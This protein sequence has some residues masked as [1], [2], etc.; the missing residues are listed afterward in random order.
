MQRPLGKKYYREHLAQLMMIITLK[1]VASM[2]N[3][4]RLIALSPDQS[5][6]ELY[7]EFCRMQ[8]NVLQSISIDPMAN[9]LQHAVTATAYCLIAEAAMKEAE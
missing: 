2:E 8:K 3:I 7:G 6:Q 5:I 9:A 4:A 1:P